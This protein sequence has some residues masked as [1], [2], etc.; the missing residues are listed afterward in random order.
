MDALPVT[1]YGAM[2]RQGIMRLAE[3]LDSAGDRQ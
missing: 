2:I 3:R 1:E